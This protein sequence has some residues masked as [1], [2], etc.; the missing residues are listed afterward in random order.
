MKN[1]VENL[2]NFMTDTNKNREKKRTEKQ[3]ARDGC[4]CKYPESK[5]ESQKC[6]SLLLEGRVSA[7]EICISNSCRGWI[8]EEMASPNP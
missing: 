3:N 8:G 6:Q 4:Y 5:L 1:E 2:K 7:K